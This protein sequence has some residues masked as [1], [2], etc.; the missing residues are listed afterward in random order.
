[1]TGTIQVFALANGQVTTTFVN[2]TVSLN[3]PTAQSALFFRLCIQSGNELVF[4]S[5][6]LGIDRLSDGLAKKIKCPT[7]F[8]RESDWSTRVRNPSEILVLFF[9]S[10]YY[11][12]SKTTR[13]ALSSCTNQFCRLIVLLHIEFQSRRKTTSS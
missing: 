13:L 9:F 1:M 7:Q 6:V 4:Q 11:I 5:A 3:L 2:C 10:N 8:S 12:N